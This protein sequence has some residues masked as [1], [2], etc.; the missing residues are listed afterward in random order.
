MGAFCFTIFHTVIRNVKSA[1]TRTCLE[2][3]ANRAWATPA[4]PF[5]I[6]HEYFESFTLHISTDALFDKVHKMSCES[7]LHSMFEI[8]SMQVNKCLI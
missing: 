5:S 6:R 8:S 7:A 2:S 4:G 1:Q 3:G